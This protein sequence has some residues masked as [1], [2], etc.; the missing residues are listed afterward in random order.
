MISHVAYAGRIS[1][2]LYPDCPALM[3]WKGSPYGDKQHGLPDL[4][5]RL[6]GLVDPEGTDICAICFN[7]WADEDLQRRADAFNDAEAEWYG[8]E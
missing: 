2:H 3:R 1:D 6:A 8:T 4:G 5:R 7:V